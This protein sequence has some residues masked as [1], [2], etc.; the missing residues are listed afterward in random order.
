MCLTALLTCEY[1]TY[2]FTLTQIFQLFDFS[3]SGQLITFQRT[4]H[5]PSL[6]S[7][8]I[9]LNSPISEVLAT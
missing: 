8:L 6:K 9:I 5:I 3:G 7:W 4:R 1:K 2:S